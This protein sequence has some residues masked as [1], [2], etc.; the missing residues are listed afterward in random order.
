MDVGNRVAKI[1]VDLIF[2]TTAVININARTVVELVYVCTAV[3]NHDAKIAVEHP[4]VCTAVK[5]PF[6]YTIDLNIVAKSVLEQVSVVI[7]E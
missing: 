7:I 6:A 3:K 2:V 1:V 4:F 5:N